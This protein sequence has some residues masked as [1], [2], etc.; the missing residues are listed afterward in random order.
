MSYFK[1]PTMGPNTSVM[2]DEHT[3]SGDSTD[4]LE[5]PPSAYESPIVDPNPIAPSDA[6]GSGLETVKETEAKSSGVTD[7][8]QAPDIK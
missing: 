6:S 5:F 2:A 4:S 8:T 3:D 7:S 1:E